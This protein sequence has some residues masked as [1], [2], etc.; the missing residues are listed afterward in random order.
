MGG[1]AVGGCSTRECFLKTVV[2]EQCPPVVLPLWYLLWKSDTLEANKWE[3]CS[4]CLFKIM[5]QQGDWVLQ[6]KMQVHSVE[7]VFYRTSLSAYI[8][9]TPSLCIVI[10]FQGACRA[11]KLYSCIHT[12]KFLITFHHSFQLCTAGMEITYRACCNI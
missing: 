8:S 5:W 12:E 9:R 2:Q 4:Y 6:K 3:P 7:L 10:F 11:F 1:A